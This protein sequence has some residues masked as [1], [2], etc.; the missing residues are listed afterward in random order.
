[1]SISQASDHIQ[2][3]LSFI[4]MREPSARLSPTRC[5]KDR[6]TASIAANAKKA[7]FLSL[8]RA[9]IRGSRL[10]PIREMIASVREVLP[11]ILV[12][13]I[14]IVAGAGVIYFL[15]GRTAAVIVGVIVA[16]LLTYFLLR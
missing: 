8:S 5:R 6:N 4:A 10:M 9:E 2:R 13:L 14:V 12:A 7:S 3:S 15:P 16:G 11:A 1:M